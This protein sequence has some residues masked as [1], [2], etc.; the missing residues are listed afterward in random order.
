MARPRAGASLC[1]FCKL[2]IHT[3]TTL[4]REEISDTER[5]QQL[6]ASAAQGVIRRSLSRPSLL[7]CV[8]SPVGIEVISCP[9]TNTSVGSQL[10]Q[11]LKL[12]DTIDIVYYVS[13]TVSTVGPE[14]LCAPTTSYY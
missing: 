2:S 4:Y 6:L 12:L 13:S 10:C 8:L 1:Y 5:T 11:L 9:L 7:Y 3:W 14:L